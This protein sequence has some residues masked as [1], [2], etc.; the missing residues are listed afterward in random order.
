MLRATRARR[1]ALQIRLPLF[2]LQRHI[3]HTHQL[4]PQVLEAMHGVRVVARAVVS[5]FGAVRDD[6]LVVRVDVVVQLGRC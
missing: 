5:E 4:R 3:R 2:P 1:P 6:Q